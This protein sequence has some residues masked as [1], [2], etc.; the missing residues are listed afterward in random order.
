[1]AVPEITNLTIEKGADFET[2]ILIPEDTLPISFDNLT[3]LSQ[4]RKYSNSIEQVT[5]ST[6]VNEE[7]R[8]ITISLTSEQTLL[9]NPGR[10]YFDILVEQNNKIYKVAKGTIIVYE[11]SSVGLTTS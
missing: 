5:C 11:T 2:T 8:E 3:V 10:N 4:I 1:M 6:S 7:E 9:L